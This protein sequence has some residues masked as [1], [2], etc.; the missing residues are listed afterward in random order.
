MALQDM[1]F[2]WG[3]WSNALLAASTAPHLEYISTMAVPTDIS[4]AKPLLIAMPCAHFDFLSSVESE[5]ASVRFNMTT[6]LVILSPISLICRHTATAS[7]GI[8]PWTNPPIIVAH[9]TVS[10]FSVLLNRLHAG[11]M[12]LHLA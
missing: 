4:A 6:G 3:R 8:P 11:S 1:M 5:Q 12:R 2:F 9:T 10:R 7:S